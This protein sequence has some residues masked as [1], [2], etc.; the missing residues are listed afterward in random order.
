MPTGAPF[1][2]D[3]LLR[4]LKADI[5]RFFPELD[6]ADYATHSFRRFGATYAKC[7][8]IPD[9]VIQ[10]VGRWVSDCFQRYFVFSD[11]DKVDMS[12]SLIP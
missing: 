8:G 3:S 7:G 6:P 4:A 5:R 12:R 2:Y 11:D 10:Y 1:L 9:D